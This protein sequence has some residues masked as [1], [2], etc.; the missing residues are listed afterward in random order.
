MVNPSRTPPASASSSSER[1]VDLAL[2]GN[3]VGIDA[4]GRAV[5]GRTLCAAFGGDKGFDSKV[6]ALLDARE[7]ERCSAWGRAIR[8]AQR[9]S[10]GTEATLRRTSI[11]L[12]TERIVLR[13]P[14]RHAELV[15]EAVEQRLKQLGKATGRSTDIEIA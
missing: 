2:H 11:A 3:W 14:R 15:G 6:G 9:L 10:A 1:A 4:H 8:L 13:I 5:L 12:E 7:E